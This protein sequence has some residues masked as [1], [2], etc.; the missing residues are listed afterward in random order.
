[1]NFLIFSKIFNKYGIALSFQKFVNYVY[2]IIISIFNIKIKHIRPYKAGAPRIVIPLIYKTTIIMI[3]IRRLVRFSSR[4][5]YEL[6][7]E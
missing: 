6:V 7:N 4:K 5:F 3:N 2:S 1:M